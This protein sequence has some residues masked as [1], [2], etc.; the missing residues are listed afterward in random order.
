MKIVL[1]FVSKAGLMVVLINLSQIV[2]YSQGLF[3]V[4]TI[5]KEHVVAK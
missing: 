4:G 2:V 3:V 1:I 5:I